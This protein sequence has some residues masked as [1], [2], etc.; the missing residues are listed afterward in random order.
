M[1]PMH[2]AAKNGRS[3]FIK[4]VIAAGLNLQFSVV[5]S[6]GNSLYHYASQA[7]KETIEVICDHS[8]LKYLYIILIIK[9]FVLQCRF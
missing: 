1:T 2:I 4:S 5:D 3:E 7:N 6:K 9:Y 8:I